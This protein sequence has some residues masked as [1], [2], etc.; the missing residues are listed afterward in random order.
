MFALTSRECSTD[1]L[2]R[3]SKEAKVRIVKLKK[4]DSTITAC[5]RVTSEYSQ[6]SDTGRRFTSDALSWLYYKS[7]TETKL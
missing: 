4:R 2:Q 5:K 7:N 6:G 3:M 1:T